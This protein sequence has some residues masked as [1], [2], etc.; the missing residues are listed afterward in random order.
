MAGGINKLAR[1]LQRHIRDSATI[2]DQL[3][4]GRILDDMSLQTDHFPVPIPKGQYLVARQL[5][6]DPNSPL[7]TTTDGA[8]SVVLPAKMYP[9]KPGDRVL[10]AWVNQGTDPVVIDIVVP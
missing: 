8:H 3:E 5:T 2:A 6:H 7:T 1:V 4:L 10:V 9:L